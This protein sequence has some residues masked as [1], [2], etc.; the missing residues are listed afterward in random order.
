AFVV[1]HGRP[2]GAGPVRE[3]ALRAGIAHLRT[4]DPGA[5]EVLAIPPGPSARARGLASAALAMAAY[6]RAAET[7]P[8]GAAAEE[9]ARD[10]GWARIWAELGRLIG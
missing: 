7:P 10:A 3:L 9:F 6:D 1:E 5:P 2:P 4:A 8:D